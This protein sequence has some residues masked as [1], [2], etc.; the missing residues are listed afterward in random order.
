MPI[1]AFF[2]VTDKLKQEL[3]SKKLQDKLQVFGYGHMG[4]GNL[5]LNITADSFLPKYTR[6]IEDFVYTYLSKLNEQRMF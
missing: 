5:H 1:A 3:A 2:D 6:I 4:D